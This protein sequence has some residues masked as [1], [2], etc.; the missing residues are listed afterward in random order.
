M[1]A[2]DRRSAS[3][4]EGRALRAAS[5]RR[6]IVPILLCCATAAVLAP[7]RGESMRIEAEIP[8]ATHNTP[9]TG[10]VVAH[11]CG[12]ASR[13]FALGGLDAEGDWAEFRLELAE[14]WCFV[15]SLRGAGLVS[16]TWQYRL[17]VYPDTSDTPVIDESYPAVPGT[18]IACPVTFQWVHAAEAHCLTAGTWYLRVIRIG[19]GD[20]RLDY[21]QLHETPVPVAATSWGRV[22]ELYRERT[23]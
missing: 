10:S 17:V 3:G 23:E 22:K 7:A 16:G 9:G 11:T 8:F 15:D 21:I 6:A 20:T 1:R 18:G 12:S 4:P 2:L 19:S 13:G 5:A 14:T